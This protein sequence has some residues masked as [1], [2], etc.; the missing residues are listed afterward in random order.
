M[1]VRMDASRPN[2]LL[3]S[4]S[5]VPVMAYVFVRVIWVTE[6]NGCI[7]ILANKIKM[8]LHST[9]GDGERLQEVGHNRMADGGTI[10]IYDDEPALT[11]EDAVV[12]THLDM[13]DESFVIIAIITVLLPAD[14]E[15]SFLPSVYED[16]SIIWMA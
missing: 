1:S 7:H 5:N 4:P 14:L 13:T 11:A 8:L 3:P 12:S 6:S 10:C 16:E 15:R 9:G 2:H